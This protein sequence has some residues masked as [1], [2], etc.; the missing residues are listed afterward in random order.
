MIYKMLFREYSEYVK[1]RENSWFSIF[2]RV[3]LEWN[4][5]GLYFAIIGKFNHTSWFSP[6]RHKRWSL[7][8]TFK[9]RKISKKHSRRIHEWFIELSVF[10]LNVRRKR[11]RRVTEMKILLWF[12]GMMTLSYDFHRNNCFK[13]ER[14]QSY[15]LHT[16][17][18]YR[19][20]I[21]YA[22]T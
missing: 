4:R 5:A 10:K 17:L 3:C 14:A 9:R 2:E 8:A 12:D 11:N 22:I 21:T 16:K 19:K 15:S 6:D 20:R 18:V 1:P 7:W 13:R